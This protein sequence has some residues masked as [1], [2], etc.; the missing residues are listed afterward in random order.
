MKQSFNSIWYIIVYSYWQ[1]FYVAIRKQQHYIHPGYNFYMLSRHVDIISI[2]VVDVSTP[3]TSFS[4]SRNFRSVCCLTRKPMWLPDF[5]PV[6]HALYAEVLPIYVL[7]DHPN[8]QFSYAWSSSFS[9]FFR[10][11]PYILLNF[12]WELSQPSSVVPV[13]S[14]LHP[15]NFNICSTFLRNSSVCMTHLSQYYYLVPFD[16]KPMIPLTEL[17]SG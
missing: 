6:A 9:L 7:C 8:F 15:W 2:L 17:S 14:S 10:K 11:I 16:A 12:L 1:N 13:P 3:V 4:S 5:N